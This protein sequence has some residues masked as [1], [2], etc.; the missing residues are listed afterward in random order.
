MIQHVKKNYVSAMMLATVVATLPACNKEEDPKAHLEKGVEYLHKGEFA[1]AELELK[2]ASQSDKST[3]ETYYYLALLDEKNR[4]FKEMKGNLFKAIELDPTHIEARLKLGN[5]LL[6][7][8]EDAQVSEQIAFLSQN[9]SKNTDV[10]ILK[11]S[12]LFKQNKFDEALAIVDE[13]LQDGPSNAA[14]LS[15]KSALYAKKG[16]VKNALAFID[17]A[18]KSDPKNIALHLLRI[19]F[20]A[21]EK[22]E[23]AIISDYQNL[24]NEFPKNRDL[25]I[26]LVKELAQMGKVDDAEKLLREVVALNAEDLQSRIVLLEFIL[27]R[28]GFGELLTT[29]FHHFVD[30]NKNKPGMLLAL[31]Q[32]MVS[33]KKYD[34]A[35]SVLQKIIQT[36]GDSKFVHAAQTLLANNALALKDWDKASA[37][38]EE[39]LADNPNYDDA[40]IVKAKL[41]LEKKQYDDAINLLDKVSWSQPKSDLVQF[42]L[43]Q[44]YLSKGEAQKA[45]AFFTKALE[46]NPANLNAFDYVY[47]KLLQKNDTQQAKALLEQTIKFV[48]GNLVL[49]ENLIKL[50]LAAGELGEAEKIIE[51]LSGMNNTV[52]QNLALFS[53]AEI[54]RNKKDYQKAISLYQDLLAKLPENESA[55]LG[56]VASY[57][58]LN[59]R[60]ESISYLN[61]LL[62]KNPNNAP[63]VALLANV[64][65]AENKSNQAI[66]LLERLVQNN[67]QVTQSYLLLSRAHMIQ[68]NPEAALLVLQKGIGLNPG[69][70]R[71]SLALASF[72]EGQRDWD[73]AVLIYEDLIKRD[74]NNTL[75]VNN[76]AS[77]LADYYEN[78]EKIAR[79]V[80][81]AEQFKNHP[82]PNLRDTYGWALIQA[83][84]TKEGLEVLRQVVIDA[85]DEAVFKYHLAFAYHQNGDS[86][87]A[88]S[89]LKQAIDLAKRKGMPEV[90]KKSELLLKQITEQAG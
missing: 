69:D 43:G 78:P 83:G 70:T 8:G 58:Q 47:N 39:V 11:A 24:I 15:L 37:L 75:A 56:L 86:G 82:N 31:S 49:L 30:E 64:Y 1:K 46:Y 48:P 36:G 12:F 44:A 60:P 81:L 87:S 17:Q 9:F 34:E 7:L 80:V 57:E 6:L 4:N 55:L 79:S 51:T 89:E 42:L 68:K 14:A 66:G 62:K 73:S 26:V 35:N 77:I 74:P 76:L 27:S 67:P 90:E 13:V 2:T 28:H 3:A 65:L 21:K 22:N 5:L 85:P 41:L 16:D 71:L 40:K 38:A 23:T 63:A 18:I 32:W 45:D 53:K 54:L 50:N 25:K 59:K 88:I 84:R 10:K 20:H 19:Q 61:D 29:Q 72:Y 52:A 33:K